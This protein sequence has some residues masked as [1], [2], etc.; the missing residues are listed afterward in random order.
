MRKK[1][2]LFFIILF[3]LSFFLLFFYSNPTLAQTGFFPSLP[4]FSIGADYGSLLNE[5]DD[6]EWLEYTIT[7]VY[8]KITQEIYKGIFYIAEG[9][10]AS[11]D[12]D[13]NDLDKNVWCLYNY[14]RIKTFPSLIIN[15][16]FG[17]KSSDYISTHPDYSFFK[18]GANVKYRFAKY[19]YFYISYAYYNRDA[20]TDYSLHYLYFSLNM[21]IWLFNFSIYSK[22]EYKIYTD[23]SSNFKFMV[24]FDLTFDLNYLVKE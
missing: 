10:Y 11:Y 17:F 24:G 15:L 22:F 23:L 7:K 20:S 16:I 21:P 14:I 6:E 3:F 8:A 5:E 9:Y 1:Q 13:N 19:S 4:S 12:F 2:K 18:V